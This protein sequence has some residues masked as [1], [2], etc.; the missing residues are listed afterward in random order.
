MIAIMDKTAVFFVLIFTF[1]IGAG[2]G[3]YLGT[4]F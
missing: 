2:F 4:L 1:L 3:F